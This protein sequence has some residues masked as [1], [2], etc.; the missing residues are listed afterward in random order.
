MDRNATYKADISSSSTSPPA[1]V[2]WIETELLALGRLENP[3]ATREGGV[4]RN[5]IVPQITIDQLKSPPAR[6]AWIETIF[7]GQLSMSSPVA[8]REGGVDRNINLL[9]R[10][11]GMTVA[12]R[13]GGVDRNISTATIRARLQ[14]SPPA[15]V[16]W[17][18]T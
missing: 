11:G 2:A 18:E 6:V 14:P 12:T 17:I 10:Y 9:I 15:R 5:I 4:D 13:E 3:V 7:L 16:A 8:T 1:R